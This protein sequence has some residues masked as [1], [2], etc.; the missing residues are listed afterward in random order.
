MVR[1]F[2][3]CTN[4][5]D[6]IC[7]LAVIRAWSLKYHGDTYTA[8]LKTIDDVHRLPVEK[9][10][11]KVIIIAQSS[12]T[13]KSKTVDKVATERILFPLCLRESLGKN[14]FGT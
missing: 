12:G 1:L 5:V 3:Q 13:G 6:Q 2:S 11:A 7:D 10:Y 9:N 4:R 14:Y 8:L